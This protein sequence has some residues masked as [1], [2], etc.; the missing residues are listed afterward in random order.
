MQLSKDENLISQN[1]KY[2]KSLFEIEQ[3]MNNIE[4]NTKLQLKLDL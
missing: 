3:E 2:G 4:L 1:F